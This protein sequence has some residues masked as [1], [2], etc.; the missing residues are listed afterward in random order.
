MNYSRHT[1][2]Q[3]LLATAVTTALGIAG[4]S[5]QAMAIELTFS[6]TGLFTMI[7]STGAGALNNTDATGAP[8]YGFRTPVVGAMIFETA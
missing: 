5:S 1:L 8:G 4:Y 6:V 2:K 7:N 3:T